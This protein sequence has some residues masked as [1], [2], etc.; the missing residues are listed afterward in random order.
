MTSWF[1]RE[2]W[3]V[4]LERAALLRLGARRAAHI[5]GRAESLSAF[6]VPGGES[7]EGGPRAKSPLST[8]ATR[9]R[10]KQHAGDDH[11]TAQH[12]PR[13]QPFAEEQGREHDGGRRANG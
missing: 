7:G 12:L 9:H 13:I 10:E 5:G 2:S 1:S 4:H 8:F 6:M 11:G 3:G